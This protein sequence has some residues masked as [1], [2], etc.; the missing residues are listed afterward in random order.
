MIDKELWNVFYHLNPN[1]GPWDNP[2]GDPDQHIVD[3]LN[4]CSLSVHSK[5]LDVGCGYGKNS[6][7]MIKQGF[8]VTGVDVAQYAISKCQ[9]DYPAHTFLPI[10]ILENTFQENCFDTIVDA[11]AMHV[12]EPSL[13]RKFFEQYHR[14]LKDNSKC[15]VRIFNTDQ[16]NKDPIFFVYLRMPVYG[17]SVKEVKELISG[18]FEIEKIIYNKDYGMHGEGCNFYYLKKI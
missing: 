10:D 18:L 12:N 16:P 15:F 14:I 6:A 1:G 8:A 13:H 4:S 5:I 7:Y 2:N 3:F 17:R 9:T 11:G